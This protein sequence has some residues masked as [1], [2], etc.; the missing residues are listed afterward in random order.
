MS[1]GMRSGAGTPSNERALG[2]LVL[3][4]CAVAAAR[5]G[6]HFKLTRIRPDRTIRG[7]VVPA[8]PRELGLRF[9]T[10]VDFRDSRHGLMGTSGGQLLATSDAG[11]S[12]RVVVRGRSV[13]ALSLVA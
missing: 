5:C 4:A 8:T 12:W 9:P 10:A 13:V 3:V 7:S 2:S 11:Q 6:S 1:I